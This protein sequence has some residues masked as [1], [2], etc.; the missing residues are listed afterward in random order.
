[1][2]FM[3]ITASTAKYT[4]TQRTSEEI[5]KTTLPQPVKTSTTMSAAS[6]QTTLSGMGLLMSRLFGDTDSTPPVQTH[7]TKDTMSMSCVNF[8]TNNDRNTLA[9][10]YARAQQQGTDLRYVD[11][12][13]RDLGDYRMFSGVM[14]NLNNGNMYDT[15]GHVLTYKFTAEDEATASRILSGGKLSGSALDEGF[16]RYELDPG[17]SPSHLANFQFIE[18]IVNQPGNHSPGMA[19]FSVYQQKGNQNFV[20]EAASEVTLKTPEPDFGSIDGKFFVTATGLK[21]GFRLE[22]GKVVQH[23]VNL[24]ENLAKT[25]KTLLDYFLKAHESD[26][27]PASLSPPLF[28]FL[29]AAEHIE[30]KQK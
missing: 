13:A 11:D 5:S 25:P 10:L 30:E 3:I 28:N 23:P 4:Q 1:M 12:L 24:F 19:Q 16:L 22:G 20:V 17:Y 21:H 6:G 18:S 7:L 9:G 8:L 2:D 14:A 15:S 26:K 27:K 29:Y